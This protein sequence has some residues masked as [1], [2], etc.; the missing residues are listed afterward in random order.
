MGPN[1][2]AARWDGTVAVVVVP[3]N[4]TAVVA[5]E[6]TAVATPAAA[7]PPYHLPTAPPRYRHEQQL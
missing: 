2:V 4:E 5:A 7:T 6:A 3:P 1:H